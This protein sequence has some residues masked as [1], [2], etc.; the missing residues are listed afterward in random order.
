MYPDELPPPFQTRGFSLIRHSLT[1]PTDYHGSTTFYA[2]TN[3]RGES[4]T[5]GVINPVSY[6]L[7]ARFIANNWAEI[8]KTYM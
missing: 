1:P 7:L 6:F 5:F 8:K 4:R 2:G 3:H